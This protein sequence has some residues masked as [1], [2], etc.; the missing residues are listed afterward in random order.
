ML[1]ADALILTTKEAVP[2]A[3]PQGLFV[4]GDLQMVFNPAAPHANSNQQEKAAQP[5]EA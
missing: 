1:A 2:A 3:R 4:A 5:Q